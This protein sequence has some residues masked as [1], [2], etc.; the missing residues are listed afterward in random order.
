[1]NGDILDI[2]AAY[3]EYDESPIFL[4]TIC[5]Y[6]KQHLDYWLRCCFH[7]FGVE[8]VKELPIKL[9]WKIRHVT[10]GHYHCWM[11]DSKSL[12]RF[13]NSICF[14]LGKASLHNLNGT[15]NILVTTLLCISKQSS[16]NTKLILHRQTRMTTK[17]FDEQN[18]KRIHHILKWIFS[19]TK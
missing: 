7:R 15:M 16:T 3:I 14:H 6:W 5:K 13:A 12:T 9:L 4:R 10:N 18:R 8:N 17:H 11:T 1:M 2:L 19:P